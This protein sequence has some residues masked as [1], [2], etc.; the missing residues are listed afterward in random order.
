[1]IFICSLILCVST[2]GISQDLEN[3]IRKQVEAYP[4]SEN[5]QKF[6]IGFSLYFLENARSKNVKPSQ[7]FLTPEEQ[8]VFDNAITETL[9]LS[10][11]AREFEQALSDEEI[12]QVIA[13]V[14]Y[15]LVPFRGLITTCS[16]L[17]IQALEKFETDTCTKTEYR[18]LKKII[19]LRELWERGQ[20][21]MYIASLKERLNAQA[22]H[23]VLQTFS[24]QKERHIKYA[25]LAHTCYETSWNPVPSFIANHLKEKKNNLITLGVNRNGIDRY[26]EYLVK[27]APHCLGRINENFQTYLKHDVARIRGE[28]WLS[29]AKIFLSTYKRPPKSLGELPLRRSDPLSNNREDPWKNE[30][31]LGAIK[32]A[33]TLRSLGEDMI[34]S[35]DDVIIGT[36]PFSPAIK[37]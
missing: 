7:P 21:V 18:A 6:K 23:K 29:Q 30:Y 22:Y 14:P 12:K 27:L 20:E 13:E 26:V 3:G 24:T 19:P 25:D 37:P 32:G 1:M 36:I 10:A 15:S 4:K 11:L 5:P 28:Y 35:K 34:P 8:V 9:R 33:I 2:T 17:A 16:D 31:V